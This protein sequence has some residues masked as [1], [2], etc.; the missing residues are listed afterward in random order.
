[1]KNRSWALILGATLV[2][3]LGL[4]LWLLWPK[5]DAQQVEIWSQGALYCTLS[6]GEDQSVQIECDAGTNT[7]TVE[8]GKVAVSFADCP[9]QYCVKRGFC[10]GGA[11]IICLPHRLEI[12]FVGQ[13]QIDGAAG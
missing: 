2:L 6:L 10:S 8:N 3:C 12:R 7:V 5:T 11:S 13:Q 9:D 4:S 1:M